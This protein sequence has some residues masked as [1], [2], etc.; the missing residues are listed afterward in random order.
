[1][2]SWYILVLNLRGPPWVSTIFIVEIFP[3]KKKKIPKL[4]F[5]IFVTVYSYSAC[6]AP[7]PKI[8]MSSVHVASLGSK[9]RI[10]MKLGLHM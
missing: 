2:G 4:C 1:M 3:L 5:L 10:L 7:G 9:E 8:Y 6:E